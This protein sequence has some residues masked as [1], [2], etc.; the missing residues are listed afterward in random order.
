M[1]TQLLADEMLDAYDSPA[2]RKIIKEALTGILAEICKDVDDVSAGL[3]N[4]IEG[5]L[6]PNL[7]K[8]SLQVILKLKK[9]LRKV[10]F[11]FIQ[12]LD[13]RV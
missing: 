5:K 12:D 9:I 4:Y 6:T 1:A 7:D 10:I 13:G 11:Y 2:T 8:V 3:K